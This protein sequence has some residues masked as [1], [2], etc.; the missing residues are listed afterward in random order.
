MPHRQGDIRL[1]AVETLPAEAEPL[2]FPS[3]LLALMPPADPGAPG[4]HQL[5]ASVGLRAYRRSAGKGAI[6]WHEIA[7]GSVSLQAR[8]QDDAVPR[9]EA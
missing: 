3:S 1:V 4:T 7:G 5:A 9:S 2:P 6:E 8:W